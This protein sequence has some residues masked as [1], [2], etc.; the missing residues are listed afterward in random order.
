MTLRETPCSFTPLP[1]R[2]SW[3]K[4]VH[5]CLIPDKISVVR[6]PH[7][8]VPFGSVLAK[9]TTRGLGAVVPPVAGDKGHDGSCE[10]FEAHGLGEKFGECGVAQVGFRDERRRSADVLR[11]GHSRLAGSSYHVELV[12]GADGGLALGVLLKHRSSTNL[13][14]LFRRYLGTTPKR[15]NP[16]HRLLRCR[17][18]LPHLH[19]PLLG[20]LLAL[21]VV[22]VFP[23]SLLP[24]HE[25]N[26]ELRGGLHLCLSRRGNWAS[27]RW[28]E[29]SLKEGCARG[30][31]RLSRARVRTLGQ[32]GTAVNRGTIP[33]H[34]RRSSRDRLGLLEELRVDGLSGQARDRRDGARHH[35]VLGSRYDVRIGTHNALRCVRRLGRGR[36]V[37]V[38][39]VRVGL[40]SHVRVHAPCEPK[41]VLALALVRIVDRPNVPLLPLPLK[42]RILLLLL[43]LK[44]K[45]LLLLLLSRGV[46]LDMGRLK[47]RTAGE[48]RGWCE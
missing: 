32:L 47:P 35:V 42:L 1:P 48:R 9:V 25:Y 7:V 46:P 10:A 21:A 4:A 39:D 41:R 45:P 19:H 23:R 24:C 20:S 18:L 11:R 6:L 16:G 40:W 13:P 2:A 28:R 8:S 44:H 12:R 26:L 29:D 3:P 15:Y 17:G 22:S 27:R 36:G 31:D 5:L 14:L 33:E 38:G 34:R 30:H 43:L 37:G